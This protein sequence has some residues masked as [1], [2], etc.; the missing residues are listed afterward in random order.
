MRQAINDLIAAFSLLT[1]LPMP[2]LSAGSKPADQARSVWAYPLVGGVVGSVGATTFL[3]LDWIGLQGMLAAGLVVAVQILLTG[4][5]HE[6]GL[7]DVADGFGG[8]RTKAKKLA[9]MRDSRLGTYGA[10]SL[11][12][13]LGL[14]WGSI[15]SLSAAQA[16]AGLIVAGILARLA[17]VGILAVLPA[18]RKDGM[19]RVVAGPPALAVNI[20]AVFAGLV[21][22][23]LL[24]P[25]VAAAAI[26]ATAATVGLTIWLARG[27]I[28]GYTGD[29][30][31]A[32]A[33]A[34]ETAVLVTLATIASGL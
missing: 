12:V 30:L 1:R 24:P 5:L 3:A 13:V 14:R 23:L 21:T 25:L 28:G 31:G 20:A 27:Q 34:A 33:L 29:V 16:I 6:D 8:G 32:G 7:A 22:L 4:A 10:I 17:V 9:I 11:I 2:E 15:A 19:G 26:L 18:A